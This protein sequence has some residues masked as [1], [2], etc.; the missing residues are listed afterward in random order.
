LGDTIFIRNERRKLLAGYL[1]S[2]ASGTF[3]GGWLPL[4][5]AWS[6]GNGAFG[7]GPVILML[8]AFGLSWLIYGVA[9]RVL[10]GLEE[11]A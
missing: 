3:V 5:A 11:A 4:F 10:L 1:N 9:S 7:H 2:I 6:L 8:F